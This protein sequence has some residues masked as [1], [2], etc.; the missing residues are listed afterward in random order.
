MHTNYEQKPLLGLHIFRPNLTIGLFRA[1][2]KLRVTF[3]VR[4]YQILVGPLAILEVV[5]VRG[6]RSA[7]A[8]LLV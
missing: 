2:F 6:K 3:W 7:S 4:A 8:T 5:L 1:L